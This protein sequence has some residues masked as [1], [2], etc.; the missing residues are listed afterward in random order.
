MFHIC[1]YWQS[2]ELAENVSK[3]IDPPFVGTVD[4]SEVEVFEMTS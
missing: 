1:F 4:V 2:G 3:I